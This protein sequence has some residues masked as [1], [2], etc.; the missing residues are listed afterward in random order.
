MQSHSLALHFSPCQRCA[1]CSC[2][3]LLPPVRIVMNCCCV[4]AS[5]L[6]VGT[7]SSAALFYNYNLCFEARTSPSSPLA[8]S[9]HW[10]SAAVTSITRNSF[11]EQCDKLESIRE[12]PPTTLPVKNNLK[13]NRSPEAISHKSL[14]FFT[15]VHTSG[16]L[17]TGEANPW[18]TSYLPR[19]LKCTPSVWPFNARQS[20]KAQF[21]TGKKSQQIFLQQISV[22]GWT[23]LLTIFLITLWRKILSTDTKQTNEKKKKF[24]SYRQ[25]RL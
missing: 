11:K 8:G 18:S 25:K 24:C 7:S 9:L 1:C 19:Q 17:W 23:P 4:L 5:S 15:F 16:G 3:S 2:V 6:N 14:F 22:N 10:F 20:P 21:P 13:I 12:L